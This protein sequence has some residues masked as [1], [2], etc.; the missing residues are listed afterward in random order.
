MSGSPLCAFFF[1]SG[2]FLCSTVCKQQICVFIRFENYEIALFLGELVQCSEQALK[3]QPHGCRI[4]RSTCYIHSFAPIP[5]AFLLWFSISVLENAPDH[6]RFLCLFC[7]LCDFFS[8][9]FLKHADGRIRSVEK[10]PR[11]IWR[12]RVV[13][14]NYRFTT[15]CEFHSYTLVLVRQFVHWVFFVN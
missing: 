7:L 5:S 11:N 9:S 13:L 6:C 4:K 15:C 1:S 12:K 10:L 14:L 2:F 3:Y 8:L